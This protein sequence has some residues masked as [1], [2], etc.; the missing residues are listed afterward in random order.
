MK[1]EEKKIK[2]LLNIFFYYDKKPN[3]F[4]TI[5]NTLLNFKDKFFIKGEFDNSEL[6]LNDIYYYLGIKDEKRGKIEDRQTQNVVISYI[7]L[8]NAK[9]LL[10]SFVKK[11]RK[12]IV[13]NDDHPFFIFLPY[14]NNAN[15]SIKELID[16]VYKVQNNFNDSRKL[17]SRNIFLE[18]KDTILE[19]I[20]LIYNYY[21]ENNENNEIEKDFNNNNNAYDI[22]N[23]VNIFVVGKRGAGKSTLINR[24]LGEKRAYAQKN[25]KTEKTKEYFHK[26]YPLKLIDSAGFEIGK[27]SELINV[28][29][30]LEAN[31]LN[32]ENISK[33]IHFI[34]YLFKKDDKFED[35]EIEII[36][37]LYSF[38]INM[39]FLITFMTEDD[40]ESSI[41]E[42]EDVLKKSF[43][44]DEKEK[45]TIIKN[46]LDNTFCLDL[47]NV[48]YSVVIY[49]LFEKINEKLKKYKEKNDNIIEYLYNYNYLVKTPD[50]T[51]LFVDE[52]KNILKEEKG[53][54]G[55]TGETEEDK[56]KI[57]NTINPDEGIII[58]YEAKDPTA[59][60]E[61]I[62]M[63]TNDNIFFGEFE[64]DREKRKN[65]AYSIVKS[66]KTPGF[67]FSTM[68]I[69]FL[70]EYLTRKSKEKMIVEI[71]NIYKFVIK[72]K[73]DELDFKENNSKFW[74]N[75][76]FKIGGFVAGIW[77]TQRVDK[78]GEKIIAELDADY[79]KMNIL[80]VYY[81][82]ANQLNKNFEM[83]K[84][85]PDNFNNSEYWYNINM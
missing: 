39:F 50:N 29:K 5:K 61:L 37:K 43:S 31:N 68:P 40:E 45:D 11:V 52:N 6:L 83:L 41:S 51:Y 14:D 85:F 3:D 65:L 69:P 15:F 19:R 75:F 46:I 81:D 70:N 9:N 13:K 10:I 64:K 82:T 18:N 66:Y 22:N 55:E 21:N 49:N 35:K 48:Q 57:I 60:L 78:L 32:S 34:F 74:V 77:N 38:N 8:D 67:W 44:K 20:E 36:K 76:V 42:F 59:V 72:K 24:L 53:E 54:A 7:S 4:D 16:E 30:F 79:A 25:A 12:S 47:L 23:T 71:S 28:E 27:D 73:L 56:K 26:T 80:N 33:R 58:N 62:K 63:E 84:D 17:D 1:Q 2:E